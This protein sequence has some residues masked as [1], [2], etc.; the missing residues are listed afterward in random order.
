MNILFF[1]LKTKL[2]KNGEAPILMRVTINGQY[3]EVRI[4][5]SVPLKQWNASKG[6]SKGKDRVANE[7]NEYL[8]ELNSLALKKHKRTKEITLISP[9]GICREMFNESFKSAKFFVMEDRKVKLKSLSS[10][11]PNPI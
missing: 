9:C 4:Q 1:V 7:L 6:R 11:L 10:L 2:L 3:D 5:R 8:T